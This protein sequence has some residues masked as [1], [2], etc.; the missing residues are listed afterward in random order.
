MTKLGAILGILVASAGAS[1]AANAVNIDVI[2]SLAPNAFGSSYWT[3]YQ[4]NVIA[5]LSQGAAQG[6][7][8]GLPSYYQ[9]TTNVTASQTIVTNFNSWMGKADPGAVFGANYANEYG[10]RM[11]FGLVVDGQ[12]SQFSISQLSF[13]GSSSDA[14]NVLG[15]SYGAG[16]YGYSAGYVGVLAG[17]DGILW[18]ADD[19]YIT[20][21][22][23]TQLVDGLIGRGSGNALE[24]LC[25]GCTIPQQQA[26]INAAA[27]YWTAPATFTGTYSIGE[28]SGSGT[29][30]IAAVPETAT[31]STMLVGFGLIGSA[32]RR[33]QRAN[34][35]A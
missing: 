8:P 3:A 31:W 14:G 18:T 33:R 4:A 26:A 9:S 30:N 24:G 6:G 22:A 15:F 23:N 17:G 11:T 34:M 7:T 32:A 25:S 2:T 13:V 28:V 19:Q 12:G 5:A 35:P 27:G 29:F 20:S 10:N 1:T 21:G 16:A